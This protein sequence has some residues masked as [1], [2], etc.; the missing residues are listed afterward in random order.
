MS[1][2]RGLSFDEMIVGLLFVVVAMRALLMPAHS[3]TYWQLRA[4]QDIWAT[5]HVPRVDS[6]SYTAAGS[7]W[8]DHEW[9]WQALVYAL[10]R[11]GG[12]PLVTAGGALIVLVAVAL[13]Y[14][15][16]T[17]AVA[18][19]FVLLLLTIPLASVVWALRPQILTLLGLAVLAGLLARERFPEGFAN[20][21][22]LPALFLVWANA[23]GGVALGGVL[24]VA[25]FFTAVARARIRGEASD[26]RRA[27]WL[28][29]MLPLCALAT[30]AT[31]LGFGI[32]RF[33]VASEARLR[34]AHINEWRPAL[35]GL[36]IAG[37]FWI[38][39][40]GFLVLL[41]RR[42]RSLRGAPWSDW[43]LVACAVALLPLAF[44]S[45]RHI[46]PFLLLAPA[47]ASR[48][49]G[50]GFR[51][52][53]GPAPASADRP[54]LNA[55]LFAV[56]AAGAVATV[57]LAWRTPLEVLNWRPLPPAVLAAVRACPG[58]LYN[59]YNEGGYLIWF[60]PERKVFVD[61]RQDPYP[62]PLLLEHVRVESGHLSPAPLF[63]R[64]GVRCSFLGADSP[65]V[66]ALSREGWR[67]LYRDDKW[68]VQ[69]APTR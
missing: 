41:V 54:R 68:A 55:A 53:R 27:L 56:L 59:H 64:F 58:P 5:G 13:A 14:R 21:L 44:R 24:L 1:K 18:T 33:V 25:A 61:N 48:L 69:E 32:F 52:R 23:H 11:A 29:A 2:R 45:L 66:A 60:L 51:L 39:A 15:L 3:D 37:A 8:P 42:W 67:S 28:G 50:E 47:A 57:A 30:A 65:T 22:A 62:L 10:H 63:E 38:L 35:P 34:Q 49:L 7:P 16:M 46:G 19:R 6:Y 26:R 12:M 9:L 17:G 4:G 36:S 31:P 43:V 20:A 40:L